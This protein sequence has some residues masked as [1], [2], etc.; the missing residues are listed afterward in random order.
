M[1]DTLNLILI[2][3]EPNLISSITWSPESNIVSGQGEE[4]VSVFVMN[5]QQ[6]TFSV[7]VIYT[8]GCTKETSITID[9]SIF[10]PAVMAMAEPDEIIQGQSTDLF[11]PFNPDYTYIWSPA[12]YIEEGMETMNNPTATP[13]Q[14]TTF[15]VTVTNADGCTASA[16]VTVE[17]IV[18]RCEEPYIFIPT[19]F[20]PNGDSSNDVFMVRGRYIDNLELMIYDRWGKEVFKTNN[21]NRGWDGRV[22]GEL[23]TPDVYGYYVRIEC[24][25][26]E[27]ITRQ[28][29]V[30]ILQ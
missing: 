18:P 6:A 28:G 22:N 30:T 16:S 25:G 19:A 27:E 15:T 8:D 9:V 3:E 21:L 24:L 12:D 10:D 7:T 23:L 20:S 2:A 26:G 17:V 1:N 4:V 29:N 5:N 13:P 11:T 14:T